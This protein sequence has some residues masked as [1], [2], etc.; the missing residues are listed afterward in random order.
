MSEALLRA[1]YGVMGARRCSTKGICRLFNP[2]NKDPKRETIRWAWG[3]AVVGGERGAAISVEN[4]YRALKSLEGTTLTLRG[5]PYT[6]REVPRVGMGSRKIWA[7]LPVEYGREAFLR[8]LR[9]RMNGEG[10]STAE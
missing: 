8:G 9:E 3:L 7:F 5:Y 2:L 10:F 6:L 1:L 4:V